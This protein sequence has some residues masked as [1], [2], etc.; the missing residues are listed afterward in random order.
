MVKPGDSTSAGVVHEED[1]DTI[2][3]QLSADEMRALLRAAAVAAGP[4]GEELPEPAAVVEPDPPKPV[5]APEVKAVERGA[6]RTFDT[7]TSAPTAVPPPEMPRVPVRGAPTQLPAE[8]PRFLPRPERTTPSA[9]APK[10]RWR[11]THVVLAV[12]A[13]LAGL[14][15]SVTYV[16]MTRET[17][18]P[19]VVEATPPVVDE[20]PPLPVETPIPEA[21]APEPVLFRNPF[22][23]SEVFEFP[24]GTTQAEARDA[25]AE[26]LMQR[27]RERVTL[28][29]ELRRRGGKTAERQAPPEHSAA[30]RS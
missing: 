29:S 12:T 13:F 11:T 15:T 25:V 9:P 7:R 2:E 4:R 30:P 18:P 23:R 14:I 1:V 3:L 22:D 26:I 8:T 28:P 16:A 20:L 5:M 6:P 24:A 10:P 19:L 27:A 17:P 21:P